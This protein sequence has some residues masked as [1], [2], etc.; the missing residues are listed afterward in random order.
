MSIEKITAEFAPTNH[1][2]QHA[3]RADGPRPMPERQ[4]DLPALQIEDD[5]GGDP[6]N[7]TGQHCLADLKKRQR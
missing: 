5:A 1:D 6:Y 2:R 4:A 3:S 7:R